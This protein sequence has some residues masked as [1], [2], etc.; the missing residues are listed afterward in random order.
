[1]PAKAISL[2]VLLIPI[3]ANAQ[4]LHLGVK[5]GIPLT[6]YFETGSSGSLHGG[7]T[8]S[9]ATRRYTF[10]ISGEWC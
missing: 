1:M 3:P 8:Y 7:A 4:S 9:A 6:E 5:A 10:G 2:L